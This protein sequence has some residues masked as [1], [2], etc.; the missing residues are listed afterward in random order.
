MLTPDQ[1]APE[2]Y[3]QNNCLSLLHFVRERFPKVV[4]NLG[5]AGQIEGYIALSDDGQRLF[6]RL[7]TRKGSIFRVDKL[8]YAEITS[9]PDALEELQQACLVKADGEP[10]ADQLLG[11]LTKAEV[12]EL[13]RLDAPKNARK[14]EIVLNILSRYSEHRIRE[15]IKNYCTWV[16][17]CF[18]QIWWLVRLLYF[19][20]S[21]QDWSAFVL[22]DLG[23]V[24]YEPVP[25]QDQYLAEPDRL[26]QE[27][28]V[29][30]LS[31]LSY[32]LEEHPG[33]AECLI[34]NL[35]DISGDR[36]IN[37][38]RDRSLLRIGR[39]AEKAQVQNLAV[40]AY[41]AVARHP[42]RERL[43][44][45]YA[46]QGQQDRCDE[47]MQAMAQAPWCG[48]ESQ[49][50]QRFGKRNAGFQPQ[51]D[52]L[53]VC[54]LGESVEQ[55]VLEVLTQQG[56]WGVHCE[57]SLVRTLTGLLYWPVIFAPVPGA[58]T[59]PFQGGPNDLYYADF[60]ESRQQQ[61]VEH[62][63]QFTDT[64]SLRTYMLALQ[65]KKW[66]V[67][68]SLVNWYLLEHFSLD[69]FLDAM[70]AEHVLKL[71]RFLIRNLN[72]RRSGLPDLFI[73]CPGG[74]YELVEVKGPGDQL[75]PGQRVWLQNLDAM[76]IPNRV[77]KVKISGASQ[78]DLSQHG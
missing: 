29:R 56:G 27:L 64:S 20:D 34:G 21:V 28:V 5:L 14:D 42:A 73:S 16:E 75:Q 50:V 11:K 76:G 24:Q 40:S 1:P 54:R 65:S 23:V 62:E 35:C 39:Y 31:G 77:I 25:L 70:P 36:L 4:A 51:T 66:G 8:T 26:N 55:Q 22:R 74:G 17:I 46:K 7:L 63:A 38:S 15:Q 72:T 52:E 57:N 12:K 13:F 33:L 78:S 49:F 68:N 53:E 60:V 59:N 19:G 67:A 30:R 3:Y 41:Q 9:L 48:E 45:I 10:P 18:P 69:M 32:R 61:L 71:T 6:A 2:D 58:F 43:A 47:V 44:R 37:R